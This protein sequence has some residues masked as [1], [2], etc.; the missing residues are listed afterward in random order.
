M[1]RRTGKTRGDFS[2]MHSALYNALQHHR[3][4]FAEDL[5]T[6][7]KPGEGNLEL[8]YSTATRS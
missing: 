8:G 6:R 5:V 3:P 2:R 4:H 1:K 7:T